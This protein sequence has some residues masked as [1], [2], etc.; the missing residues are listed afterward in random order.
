MGRRK[1]GPCSMETWA[2]HHGLPDHSPYSVMV[3]P[4]LQA[5]S[6]S[7]HEELTRGRSKHLAS[8]FNNTVPADSTPHTICKE[9]LWQLRPGVGTHPCPPDKPRRMTRC[10]SEGISDLQHGSQRYMSNRHSSGR[11]STK[12]KLDLEALRTFGG[13]HMGAL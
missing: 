8:C 9:P 11:R 2:K 1:T 12:G 7:G 10:R 4:S 6:G 5:P 13:E 3:G